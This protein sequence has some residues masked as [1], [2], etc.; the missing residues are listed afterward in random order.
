MTTA[1]LIATDTATE[2]I[3]ETQIFELIGWK[4]YSKTLRLYCAEPLNLIYTNKKVVGEA[5]SQYLITP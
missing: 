1:F 3:N 4:T 5:P 2:E